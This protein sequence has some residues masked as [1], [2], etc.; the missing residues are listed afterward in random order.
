MIRDFNDYHVM[1]KLFTYKYFRSSQLMD[2]VD[3]HVILNNPRFLTL[4]M[5]LNQLTNFFCP[6]EEEEVESAENPIVIVK[7]EGF[8]E[9][10]RIKTPHHNNHHLWNLNPLCVLYRTSGSLLLFAG[11]LNDFFVNN[12]FS[13]FLR[14][15]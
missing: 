10:W 5:W 12:I 4:T 8:S 7:D 2:E 3:E 6:W 1:Q 9:K 13:N 11:S 15:L 14:S